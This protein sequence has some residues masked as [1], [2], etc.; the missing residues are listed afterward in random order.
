VQLHIRIAVASMTTNSMA[1][2]FSQ[3]QVLAKLVFPNA[4]S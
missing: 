3:R 1:A 4:N 2:T